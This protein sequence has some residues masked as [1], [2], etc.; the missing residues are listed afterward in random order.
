MITGTETQTVWRRARREDLDVLLDIE[1]R[2]F[3]VPWTWGEMEEEFQLDYSR[4]WVAEQDG[5]V[6]AFGIHWLI[7]GE[8]QLADIAVHP[9]F[10]RRGLGRRMMDVL[11]DDAR[12]LGMKKMTLEVRAEN[13]AAI[14]LYLN[15][16]FVETSRRPRYYED[17]HDAVLMEIS[18]EK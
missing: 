18:F 10:Q 14:D 6:V 8:S 11:L 4:P 2:S 16:G 12:A 9:D 13:A 17:R 1:R 15:L 5:R 3:D 7:A